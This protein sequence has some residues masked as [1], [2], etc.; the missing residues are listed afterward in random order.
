MSGVRPCSSTTRLKISRN[1]GVVVMCANGLFA[2]SGR[3]VKKS[4]GSFTM[5]RKKTG[6]PSMTLTAS[7]TLTPNVGRLEKK[8]K[9]ENDAEGNLKAFSSS[10]K[11]WQ[12]VAEKLCVA[13]GATCWHARVAWM[14]LTAILVGALGCLFKGQSTNVGIALRV[15][16]KYK[17]ES[18]CKAPFF[19]VPKSHS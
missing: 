9:Y 18:F 7:A 1:P 15:T 3:N 19:S 11:H 14:H 4:S 6:L 8:K 17:M 2:H 5:W 12:C 13:A 16:E 10:N